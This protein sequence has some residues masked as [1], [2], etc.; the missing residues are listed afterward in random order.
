MKIWL[1]LDGRQQGPF[2]VDE[3]RELPLTKDTKVWFAGLPKWYPAGLL[4]EMRD[5]LAL[6]EQQQA[7]EVPAELAAEPQADDVATEMTQNDSL[8]EE[9]QIEEAQQE[10]SQHEYQPEEPGQED[11][12][13][14]AYDGTP[15]YG[16][17]VYEPQPMWE[18]L[19]QQAPP[20]VAQD[21]YPQAP[22]PEC[23]SDYLPW[24]IVSTI[25]LCS[26]IAVISI[27]TSVMVRR[28]FD[29]GNVATATRMSKTTAWLIMVSWALG[30][31]P[32]II[33]LAM[34]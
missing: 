17:P 14:E 21:F 19:P 30:F 32:W 24:A 6:K 26:P 31:F 10:E 4:P 16:E 3:L 25:L 8:Q 18:P 27:I 15:A 29:R 12:R 33:M 22:A 28:Y 34:L 11:Y 7:V 20:F 1:F 5:I 2:S 13:Q 23:P 9:F